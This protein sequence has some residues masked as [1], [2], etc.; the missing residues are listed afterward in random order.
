MTE[1]QSVF[2]TLPAVQGKKM[3]DWQNGDQG[4]A[5]GSPA[6]GQGT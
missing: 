4:S 5:L 2:G 1:E 3:K 6:L